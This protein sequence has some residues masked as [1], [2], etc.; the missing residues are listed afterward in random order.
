MFKVVRVCIFWIVRV[1]W[2]RSWFCFRLVLNEIAKMYEVLMS[3][4]LFIRIKL[5]IEQRG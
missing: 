2:F 4:V 1:D 5:C 3:I